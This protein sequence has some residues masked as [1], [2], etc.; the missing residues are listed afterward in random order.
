MT[1]TQDI[2]DLKPPAL[3]GVLVCDAL[4]LRDGIVGRN[5]KRTDSLLA[6][7]DRMTQVKVKGR[8]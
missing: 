7:G 1:S 8:K 3:R 5:P 4:M 2:A 6:S